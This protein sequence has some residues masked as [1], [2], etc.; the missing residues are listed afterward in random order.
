MNNDTKSFLKMP[1]SRYSR[2]EVKIKIKRRETKPDS[3]GRL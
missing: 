3:P 1:T 2:R